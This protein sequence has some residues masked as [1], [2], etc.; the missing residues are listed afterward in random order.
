M[1]SQYRGYEIRHR[2]VRDEEGF[3]RYDAEINVGGEWRL[4]SWEA[5][6]DETMERDL[7]AFITKFE[8]THFP[9]QAQAAAQ[10]GDHKWCSSAM[11]SDAAAE[12][13][14]GEQFKPSYA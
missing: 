7:D 8:A 11:D 4:A 13:G 3:P 12:R 5:L 1:S 10:N 2:T 14:Q 6:D 9:R